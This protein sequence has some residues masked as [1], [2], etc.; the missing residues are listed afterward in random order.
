MAD[1]GGWAALANSTS[2]LPALGMS[3]IGLRERNEDRDLTRGLMEQRLGMQEETAKQTNLLHQGQLAAAEAKI[4]KD[5]QPFNPSMVDMAQAASVAKFGP[6]ATKAMVP[7]MDK[8][9]EVAA[10]DPKST[11]GDAYQAAISFYPTAREGIIND[12]SKQLASGKLTPDEQQKVSQLLDLAHYDKTGESFLGNGIFKNTAEA[13]KQREANSP[14]AIETLKQEGK[15]AKGEWS[16]PF[17]MGGAWVQQ[18]NVT[19]QIHQAVGRAPVGE[20]DT[21]KLKKMDDKAR[22]IE[23]DAAAE[24]K[25]QTLLKF[26]IQPSFTTDTEGKVQIAWPA[27]KPEVFQYYQDT[28][29]KITGEKTKAAVKRG[30]LSKDYLP[31]APASGGPLPTETPAPEA[32]ELVKDKDGN[33]VWQSK[34][35]K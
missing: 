34:V 8:I 28:Q 18:N 11:F 3:M 32:R 20:G 9:K 17:N 33:Y 35:R 6:T 12:L 23:K 30:L 10:T 29:A 27:N 7:M 22:Q 14:A 19:G 31:E 21:A 25:R 4:P 24:A 5:Q 13:I 26:N 1:S 15:P 2:H 16:E